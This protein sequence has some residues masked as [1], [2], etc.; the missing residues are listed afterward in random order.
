VRHGGEIEL[1][2]VVKSVVWP[3]GKPL[4][5]ECLRPRLIS[6]LRPREHPVPTFR[7]ECGIYATDLREA[8]QYL[9]DSVPFDLGRVVGRVALWGTVVECERGLRASHA[10][11]A[12][13]YVPIASG[14]G[15]LKL[16]VDVA[17]ALE[18]YGVPIELLPPGRLDV[19]PAAVAS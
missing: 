14:E 12:A 5:A 18:R 9:K 6:A 13:L 1:A 4:V 3:A 19:A 15:A 11:P 8:S 16:A 10:Y 2:G 17:T 7:C